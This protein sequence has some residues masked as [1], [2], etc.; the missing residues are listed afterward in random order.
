VETPVSA[1]TWA[2]V[3]GALSRHDVALSLPVR[4]RYPTLSTNTPPI[5]QQPAV[6]TGNIRPIE[7][8][9]ERA[10]VVFVTGRFRIGSLN[11]LTSRILEGPLFGVDISY[12][13]G[14][15]QIVF[16]RAKH[17]IA[18]VERNKQLIGEGRHGCFGQGYKV[19]SIQF[20]DWTDEIRQMEN[21]PKERRRLTFARAGL[22]GEKLSFK[23]FQADLVAV[24]S[25]N[26]IDLIWAFNAGNSK[27][28]QASLRGIR[29]AS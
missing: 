24:A 14:F 11:Y 29:T 28:K 9:E 4:A 23:K 1:N 6:P 20:M 26:G 8:D 5:P 19:A 16:Q 15:A 3:A 2:K 10:G 18:F 21:R 13:N 17:A 22:L 25:T 7:T 12:N 27:L